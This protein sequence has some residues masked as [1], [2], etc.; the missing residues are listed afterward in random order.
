MFLFALSNNN[1]F[2]QNHLMLLVEIATNLDNEETVDKLVNA[3]YVND[4]KNIF[5]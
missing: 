1:E 3:K 4:I 2:V 5:I